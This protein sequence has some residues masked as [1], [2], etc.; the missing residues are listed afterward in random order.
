MST[1]RAFRPESVG[2]RSSE[3][4]ASDLPR[5][6]LGNELLDEQPWRARDGVKSSE[7]L[8]LTSARHALDA[9]AACPDG[10][11]DDRLSQRQPGKRPGHQGGVGFDDRTRGERR[12]PLGEVGQIG[13]VEIPAHEIGRIEDSGR[14]ESVEPRAVVGNPR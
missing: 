7:R 6:D 4:H 5:G 10:R 14:F 1:N 3:E 9:Y 8:G 12:A 13:L 11:L 2:K